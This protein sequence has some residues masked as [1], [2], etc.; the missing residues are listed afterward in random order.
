MQVFI[1]YTLLTLVRVIFEHKLQHIYNILA[2]ILQY[3]IKFY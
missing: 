2:A 1:L 3:D